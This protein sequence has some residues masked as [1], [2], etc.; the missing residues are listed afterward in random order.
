MAYRIGGHIYH[1]QSYHQTKA[2]AKKEADW[3]RS[4]G[5]R[6]QVRKLVGEKW[7]VLVR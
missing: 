1:I 2:T 3:I 6:A 4:H 7:A 5:K